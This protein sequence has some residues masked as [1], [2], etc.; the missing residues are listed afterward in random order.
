MV[1][2][3]FKFLPSLKGHSRGNDAETV[4]SFTD[5][6]GNDDLRKKASSLQL[7]FLL[8]VLELSKIEPSCA[9]TPTHVLFLIVYLADIIVLL[10]SQRL[11]GPDPQPQ[12]IDVLLPEFRKKKSCPSGSWWWVFNL[13]STLLFDFCHLLDLMRKIK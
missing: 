6:P 13:D 4:T 12:K 9:Y 8:Q 5:L 7:F 1:A 11:T 3:P 2:R 10:P